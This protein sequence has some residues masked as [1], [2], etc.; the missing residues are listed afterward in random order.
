MPPILGT[1]HKKLSKREGAKSVL[2]YLDEGYLPEAIV[3]FLALL[4][5]SPKGNQE[6]FSQAELTREFSLDRINKNSPIFNIEKLNWFNG[7]WIRKIDDSHLVDLIAAR[8]PNITKQQIADNLPLV[9]DRLS[10]L[11]DFPRIACFL[12]KEEVDVDP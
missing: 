2:E 6:I 12:F 5:W 9:K 11:D 4:G 1:N 8:H 3:N 7:Q 10:N